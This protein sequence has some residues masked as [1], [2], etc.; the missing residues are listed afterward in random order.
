MSE[1]SNLNVTIPWSSFFKPAPL[2]SAEPP[3]YFS[4]TNMRLL[5]LIITNDIFYDGFNDLKDGMAQIKLQIGGVQQ[6]LNVFQQQLQQQLN[7]LQQQ[8]QQQ[9]NGLQQQMTQLINMVQQLLARESSQHV[10]QTVPSVEQT[11]PQSS[12]PRKKSLISI[13][14]KKVLK[15]LR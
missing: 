1:L 7:G 15:L 6:Q 13:F 5:Y 14:R 10:S 9:R 8:L 4:E 12:T 3:F 2:Y 11:L